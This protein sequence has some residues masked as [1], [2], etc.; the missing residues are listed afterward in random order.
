MAQ[1]TTDLTTFKINYLTQ[2]TYNSA[3]SSG[4]IDNNQLYFISDTLP[5]FNITLSSTQPTSQ[6]TGDFWYQIL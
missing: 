5:S 3:L 2:S 6:S 4:T 1:T